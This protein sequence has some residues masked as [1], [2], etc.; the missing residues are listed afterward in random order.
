MVTAMKTKDKEIR[1]RFLNLFYSFR[2]QIM[3]IVVCCNFL[4]VL[5]FVSWLVSS[6]TKEMRCFFMINIV[7]F[8]F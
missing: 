8:S 6:G 4:R 2:D 7:V 5:S 3:I 1:C